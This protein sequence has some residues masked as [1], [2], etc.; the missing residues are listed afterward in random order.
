[1]KKKLDRRKFLAVSGVGS[2]LLWASCSGPEED[3]RGEQAG[4]QKAGFQ[5]FSTRDAR[6]LEALAEVVLAPKENMPALSQ[7]DLLRYLDRQYAS[8]D[9]SRRLAEALQGIREE[10][11]SQ[12]GR[13]FE[14]LSPTQQQEIVDSLRQEGGKAAAWQSLSSSQFL[15]QLRGHLVDGYYNHPLVWEAI[16]FGGR[17]QF[18]GYPDYQQWPEAHPQDEG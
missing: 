5:S 17:A 1:M 12:G 9:Q 4:E 2:G 7:T 18:T 11:N 15:N 10:A 8:E 16:G 3:R 6:L 13:E 14:D